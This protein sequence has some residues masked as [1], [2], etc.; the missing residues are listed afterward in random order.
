MSKRRR[1]RTGKLAGGDSQYGRGRTAAGQQTPV[2]TP[3]E[4]RYDPKQGPQQCFV[5]ELIDASSGHAKRWRDVG[6]TTLALAYH[7]GHLASPSDDARG[8]TAEDR[9]AA[10]QH[11]ERLWYR[12]SCTGF[13]SLERVGGSPRLHWWDDR[14]ADASFAISRIAA[15]MHPKN[16]LIVSRFCGE[17]LS[18]SASVRGLGDSNGGKAI[19]IREAMDDLVAVTTG[20]RAA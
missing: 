20:R 13:M 9:Y 14:K 15:H 2:Q 7:R 10:G 11:F 1:R 19:R 3:S 12:R 5:E 16:Y 4:A 18:M 17:G 8:I 6:E